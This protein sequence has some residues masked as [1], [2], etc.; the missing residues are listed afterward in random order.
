MLDSR[1]SDIS[2][3]SSYSIIGSDDEGRVRCAQAGRIYDSGDRSFADLVADQSFCYGSSRFRAGMPRAEVSIPSA[4]RIK[5]RFVYSGALWVH[6]EYTGK[7]FP[8]ILVR[9]S[10]TYALAHWNTEYTIGMVRDFTDP[11]KM[12]PIYGYPVRN[13]EKPFTFYDLD[14][15]PMHWY[16]MHMSRDE[17]I[18][19]LERY[20]SAYL[21]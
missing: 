10:R 19:D 18:D 6:P 2:D 7:G 3:A 11:A 12:S 17:L 13:F 5:G 8:S 1:L 9:V 21:P 20:I 4:G 15:Q 16:V 14:V